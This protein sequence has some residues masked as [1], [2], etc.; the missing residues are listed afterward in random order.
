MIEAAVYKNAQLNAGGMFRRAGLVIS[1]EEITGIEVVDFGLNRFETEGASILTFV[2]TG[3]IA[4]K[5][6]ALF[7]NQT[8]PEHW[9]PPVGDDPG[10]EETIRAIWGDLRVYFPGE[11]TISEG[12]IPVG[13]ENYYTCLNEIIMAPSDQMTLEPG[14]KHWFRAGPQGAV[15]YSFSTIARDVLDGFTDQNVERITKIVED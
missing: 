12:S 2:Q 3:R 4:V 7:P 13:K 6:I 14:E 8:L 1:D 10:K 5:V 9:H 15:L 11:D